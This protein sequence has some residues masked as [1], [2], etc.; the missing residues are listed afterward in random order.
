MP[1]DPDSP[2]AEGR[3][4]EARFIGLARAGNTPRQA[5][6]KLKIP[7][8]TAIGAYKRLGLPTTRKDG[9]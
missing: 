6:E 3:R 8:E 2:R 9:R 5:A 1:P 4:R 7:V